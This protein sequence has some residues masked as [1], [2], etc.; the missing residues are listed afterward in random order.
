MK[1]TAT[2]QRETKN[3]CTRITSCL[4]HYGTQSLTQEN[5]KNTST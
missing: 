3:K 2:I 5:L 4:I 1:I